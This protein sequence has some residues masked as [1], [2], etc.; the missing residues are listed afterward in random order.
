MRL[1]HISDVAP[2]YAEGTIGAFLSLGEIPTDPDSLELYPF[3]TKEQ[4]LLL[5]QSAEPITNKVV[6][7]LLPF[8]KLCPYTSARSIELLKE[9]P[10][11]CINKIL[12]FLDGQLVGALI[13][14]RG[15]EVNYALVTSKQIDE[16]LPTHS[17]VERETKEKIKLLPIKILNCLLPKMS[18]Q[19]MWVPKNH[20]QNRELNLKSLPRTKIE[21]MFPMS[22]MKKKDTIER[23]AH[24]SG[25][26]RT[27]VNKF[28]KLA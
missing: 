17:M 9:L 12:P 11:D 20:L 18:L 13:K 4:V 5:L 2:D 27:C 25:E 3:L 19:L 1:M 26:N 23:I 10:I 14:A 8:S 6:S 7:A 28:F 21:L 24:L 16:M 22:F 15:E